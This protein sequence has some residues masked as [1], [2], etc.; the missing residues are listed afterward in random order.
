M[1][2]A[3]IESLV[4]G[5]L[6]MPSI[7][8]LRQSEPHDGIDPDLVLPILIGTTEASSIAAAI[9]GEATERPLTHAL[10]VDVVKSLGGAVSRVVIDR[11][12]G[13]IYYCT[14]YLRMQNGMFARVD[15]R[16]SDAIALAVRTNSPI[17][18]E[19]EVFQNAGT[20]RSFSASPCDKRI[21]MEEFDK[22]IEQVKPEDFVAHYSESGS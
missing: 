17:F 1:I 20:P 10:T 2:L 13:T 6:P 15:A 4:I 22:F 21:E 12:D 19:D 11:V 18:V 16:P 14:V 8:T 9:E 3:N 7:I 5:Y